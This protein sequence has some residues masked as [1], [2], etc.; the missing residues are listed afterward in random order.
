MANQIIRIPMAPDEPTTAKYQELCPDTSLPKPS[1]VIK[2]MEFEGEAAP[3]FEPSE[4]RVV[5]IPVKPIGGGC[6]KK[7]SVWMTQGCPGTPP[8]TWDDVE[9]AEVIDQS[10]SVVVA[11]FGGFG[12]YN[13]S[14]SGVGFSLEKAITEKGEY[15][16]ILHSSPTA[17]GTAVI[18]IVDECETEV[19]AG[20]R[21]VAGHWQQV[22]TCTDHFR[23]CPD[24]FIGKGYDTKTDYG[25]GAVLTKT[26]FGFK[27]E[28]AFSLCTTQTWYLGCW[29]CDNI[30]CWVVGC[31]RGLYPHPQ[32]CLLR[33]PVSC[34]DIVK[35]SLYD[36][37]VGYIFPCCRNE[38]KPYCFVVKIR[39][40]FEWVC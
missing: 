36:R 32:S 4:L 39:F 5:S 6:D 37:N 22:G 3:S 16:N 33:D 2:I 25:S 9:S 40:L 8:L 1:C 7:V 10:D 35:D 38:T 27:V 20:V 13:W 26:I 34:T 12:P 30:D 19:E 18:T 15:E 14:V 24:I 23:A 11:V 17:C 31:C 21:C 28:E 29:Q